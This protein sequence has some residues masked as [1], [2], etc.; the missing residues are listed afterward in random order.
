[1]ASS[2]PPSPSLP[3]LTALAPLEL[4]S[5]RTD[6]F[7]GEENP[8]HLDE[9]E[10]SDLQ[11]LNTVYRILSD[12]FSRLRMVYQHP[13]ECLQA[14]RTFLANTSGDELIA[15]AQVMGMASREKNPSDHLSRIFHD[16][17][18]GAL[19]GLSMRL[20]LIDYPSTRPEDAQQVFF[21]TRDHLKIMRNCVADIDATLRQADTQHRDHHLQL[22]IE[23][24]TEAHLGGGGRDLHVEV[25][26]YYEG[27]ICESCLEFSTLDRIIYNM[28]NNA[29]RF[30]AD[31]RV[32]FTMLPVPAEKPANIRF[33]IANKVAPEQ[34]QILVERFGENMGNV[35]RG[36]FTTGGNGL[37]LRICADFCAQA[38]GVSNFDMALKGG[39]FGA[40]LQDDLFLIW[41]H[42]PL[43]AE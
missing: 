35:L 4:A 12:L 41:F 43:Q 39:Y 14:V 18:G 15:A 6:R 2:F 37:G 32:Q 22:L 40:E 33:V 11:A 27:V 26:C 10:A 31:R 34:S 9:L 1:M 42:W 29:S 38:Y 30:A 16:L 25:A 21:L 36:G 23:K 17:R 24:W 28:M 8:I 19:P 20:Q 13:A 3:Q 5:F 7:R